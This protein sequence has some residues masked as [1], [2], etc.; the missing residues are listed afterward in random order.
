[1]KKVGQSDK[2]VVP[3]S[4]LN[5]SIP[6]DVD[7]TILTALE[8]DP[9]NRFRDAREFQVELR[10]N[11][12]KYF[13]DHT[14][15]NTG[16]LVKSLFSED[17]IKQRQ[18]TKQVNQQA[19]EM[20][21]GS[22]DDDTAVITLGELTARNVNEKSGERGQVSE[23]MVAF[24]LSKIEAALKQKASTR[25]YMMLAFYIVTIIALKFGDLHNIWMDYA[26][27]NAAAETIS[28]ATTSRSMVKAAA[29]RR[30]HSGTRQVH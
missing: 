4:S 24:R 18:H 19:Q 2:H 9:N 1:M 5:N 8:R 3:P 12:L 10:K 27:P 26:T 14:Y 28:S 17:M 22:A 25:H 16:E 23:E 13:P 15:A 7:R 20:L 11:L 29:G 6:A 21:A 30:A